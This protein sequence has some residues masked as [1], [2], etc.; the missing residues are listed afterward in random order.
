MPHGNARIFRILGRRAIVGQGQAFEKG[1]EMNLSLSLALLLQRALRKR[2]WGKGDVRN[3]HPF[4][5][6]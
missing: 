6:S 3:K 2:S 4:T 5:V 1:G